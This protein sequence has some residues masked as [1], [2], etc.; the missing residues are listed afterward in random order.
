MLAVDVHVDRVLV[1]LGLVD[2]GATWAADDQQANT[3]RPVRQ[4][5]DLHVLLVR[6]GQEP[7]ACLSPRC[8]SCPLQAACPSAHQASKARAD[9]I[10]GLR[11]TPRQRAG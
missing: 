6:H 5:Y 11:R 8:Q 1:R 4:R 9:H 10:V 2:A 3:S 7:C